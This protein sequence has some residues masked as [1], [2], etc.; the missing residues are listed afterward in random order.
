M[1]PYTESSSI[2]HFFLRRFQA[3]RLVHLGGFYVV[4]ID[5][6]RRSRY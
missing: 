1:S 6:G 5:V 4:Q 2:A 3:F